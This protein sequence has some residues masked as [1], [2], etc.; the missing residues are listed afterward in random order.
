M[1]PQIRIRFGLEANIIGESGQLDVDGEMI[2]QL[3]IL[4]A[5][6]HFGALSSNLGS[7]LKIHGE[8]FWP[9]IFQR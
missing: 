1:F 7:T 4:L 9:D 8:I 5:G 3:D 6:Y 2:R